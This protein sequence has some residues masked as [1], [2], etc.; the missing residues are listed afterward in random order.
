MLS[1]EDYLTKLEYNLMVKAGRWI[2]D[3]NES[4][5][6][7]TMDGVTFSMF[8]RGG[9]RPKGFALS[10]LAAFL[11]VPNYQAAC[12]VLGDAPNG[13]QFTKIL[14]TLKRYRKDQEVAWTW[15]VI[16]SESKFSPQL[17][18]QVEKN[19]DRHTG[20]ALID[21]STE[22][23]ITSQSYVARRMESVVNCF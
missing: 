23:I 20:I 9:M 3:F 18:A 5:L 22:E 15:L 19:D 21:L 14:Q 2:A 6:D 10:K 11:F 8:I 16:L 7:Y 1:S 4:I 12:Y 17:V 13:H